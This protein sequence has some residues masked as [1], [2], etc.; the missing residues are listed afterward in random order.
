MHVGSSTQAVG[1]H[2][3]SDEP[4]D[5]GALPALPGTARPCPPTA[6]PA[7]P[8]GLKLESTGVSAQTRREGTPGA[9]PRA[10]HETPEAYSQPAHFGG[11]DQ[12]AFSL[13][14]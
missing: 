6:L 3:T 11:H 12:Q 14:P 7:S 8:R 1:T 10:P 4:C 2:S 9:H 5:A 13:H